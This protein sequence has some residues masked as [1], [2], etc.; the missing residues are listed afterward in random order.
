MLSSAEL[1]KPVLLAVKIVAVFVCLYLF[2]VGVSGMGEAFKMFGREFAER[3]LATTAN[4]ITGLFLGILATSLVQSSSTSTSIIVGMV[5][6]GAISLEGAIPMIMGANIGTTL[7]AMLISLGHIN[8]PHEFEPAFGAGM[9]HMTFNLIAVA[10]LFP[11]E[12][13]TGLVTQG[14]TTLSNLFQDMGGMRIS[15][16]L[17]AA[18]EPAIKLLVFLLF[19]NAV[20]LLVVTV[21][22][23]FGML[24]AIVKLLRSLVLKRLE[25]FFDKYLF[26]NWRRAMAFGFLLT[27][28]VQSSSI[29]TALVVPL[30][31]AGILKL[32]QVYPFNLGANVGTTITA[33]LAALATANPTAI[34]VAFAHVLFNVLGI[35]LIWSI[36]PV[37]RIPLVIAEYVASKGARRRIIPFII[38]GGVYFLIPLLV[39]ILIH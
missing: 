31:G 21:T 14:A 1:P 7:T 18:T 10:I 24:I 34:T 6:G 17:K 32:I 28:A 12:M 25:A 20:L 5:A 22:L 19:D 33:M 23:T 27:V 2:I 35:L 37:R 8:R 29:P 36:P 38:I 9:L 4:P 11:L 15:N 3:V 39:V 30:A 26:L 13:A 16:P